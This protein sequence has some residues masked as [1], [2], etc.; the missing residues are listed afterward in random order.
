MRFMRPVDLQRADPGAID[1]DCNRALE[2]GHR[3]HEAVSASELDQYSFQAGKRALLEPDEV[4]DPQERPRKRRKPGS[5][6][7]TDGLDLGVAHRNRS[8]S[9]ADD[10][11][12]ARR[13]QD[14]KATKGVKATEQISREKR[15]MHVLEAVGP[16]APGSVKRQEFRVS[17]A[18]QQ[19]CHM[20]F[21]TG[22]HLQREPGVRAI[23]LV[24]SI[25]FSSK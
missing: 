19:A 8:P 4:A 22:L 20:L 3:N 23:H 15:E 13:R 9:Y 17:L 25:A 10:V 14:G 7:S 6:D 5:Y 24:R 1:L 11:L 16:A 12:D 21:T 2:K 18:A